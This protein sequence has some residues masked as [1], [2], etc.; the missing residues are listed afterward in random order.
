MSAF[1]FASHNPR[2]SRFLA[3]ASV[4]ALIASVTVGA[5]YVWGPTD[6]A[7]VSPFGLRSW[8]APSHANVSNRTK[9]L[10]N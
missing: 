10:S 6:I 5:M 1:K 9:A 2:P 3:S 8:N 4:A 7:T